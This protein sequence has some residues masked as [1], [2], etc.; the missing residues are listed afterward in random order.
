MKVFNNIIV[1]V[2]LLV[3]S[4]GS[5]ESIKEKEKTIDKEDQIEEIDSTTQLKTVYTGSL[6][7]YSL[8][9]FNIKRA[10]MD[11]KIYKSGEGVCIINLTLDSLQKIILQCQIQAEQC[12]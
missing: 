7:G 1:L 11:Y 6:V 5:N 3:S 10:G 4:C 2:L 8:N 9:E 12:K